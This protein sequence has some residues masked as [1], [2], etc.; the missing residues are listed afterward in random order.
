MRIRLCSLALTAF[1]V[2]TGCE[3]SPEPLSAP[4]DVEI[5]TELLG[6]WQAEDED[7][8]ISVMQVLPFNESEYL[9]ILDAPDEE[10]DGYFRVWE[11]VVDGDIWANIQCVGC[12]TDEG[13]LLARLAADSETMEI[14][15]VVDDFYEMVEDA[16]T[17]ADVVAA[18]RRAASER[19]IMA[20]EVWVW[21][22]R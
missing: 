20:D 17:T 2:L 5:R 12:D 16:E 6:E 9:A 4:G 11:S 18:L 13:F 14:G 10:M 19:S 15:W 1:L 21:Q 3:G 8:Q 7:G 22:R